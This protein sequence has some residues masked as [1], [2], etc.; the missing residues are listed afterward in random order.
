MS[1]GQRLVADR[2]GFEPTDG[3]RRHLVST[4]A[5]SARLADLSVM[6]VRARLELAQGFIPTPVFGTGGLPISLYLTFVLVNGA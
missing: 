5:A 6:A 2:V 1:D 3:F 4:E